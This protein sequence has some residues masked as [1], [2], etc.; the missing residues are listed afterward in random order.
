MLQSHLLRFLFESGEFST[1]PDTEG[2]GEDFAFTQTLSHWQECWEQ[3]RFP[4]STHKERSDHF[5]YLVKPISDNILRRNFQ[6]GFIEISGEHLSRVR[7]R[8]NK[9]RLP[10]AIH[11]FLANRECRLVFLLVCNGAKLRANDAF[12]QDFLSYFSYYPELAFRLN[13]PIGVVVSDPEAASVL[14]SRQTDMYQAAFQP[15]SDGF[16]AN[17]VIKK[18]LPQTYGR[19]NG[20]KRKPIVTGFSVGEVVSV[21]GQVR[22]VRPDF[23]DARKLF[24]WIYRVLTR[25]LLAPN[26]QLY[27]NED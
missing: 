26:Y 14:L 12:F 5:R 4:D 16:N 2:S 13:T 1:N 19:L 8:G 10:D 15:G 25:R 22:L 27:L 7:G 23:N 20:W 6:F 11:A 18:F 3:G 17:V 24:G 21:Q 9:P